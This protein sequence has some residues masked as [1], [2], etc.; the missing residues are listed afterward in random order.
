MNQPTHDDHW[1]VKPGSIRRIWQIFYVVLAVTV[2]AQVYIKVKPYFG[3]DGWFAFAAI[4]G[5]LSCAAMVLVAKLLGV[6]LKRSDDYYD[7]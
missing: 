2:L 4:F 5:F 3:I 6:F 1:L 7:E